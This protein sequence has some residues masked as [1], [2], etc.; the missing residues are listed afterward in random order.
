MQKKKN[1][2]STRPRRPRRAATISS[3]PASL[4]LLWG[5]DSVL[6]LEVGSSP[7]QS[8]T[9]E[10]IVSLEPNIHRNLDQCSLL[11]VA[12]LELVHDRRNL[13]TNHLHCKNHM[14]NIF[15]SFRRHEHDPLQW[16]PAALPPTCPASLLSHHASHA[17]WTLSYN[18]S[19]RQSRQNG[20]IRVDP[21]TP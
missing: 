9:H 13:L 7:L 6:L 5:P 1:S 8:H 3:R 17:E 12:P 4:P 14:L 16:D 15:V 10:H 11:E 20:L 18:H 21:Q 19:I 2:C